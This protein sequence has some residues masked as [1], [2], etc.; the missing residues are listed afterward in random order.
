MTQHYESK[1]N[2]I[3]YRVIFLR[4]KYTIM[5]IWEDSR[6]RL[7]TRNIAPVEMKSETLDELKS[8]IIRAKRAIN[9]PIVLE[10]E[11]FIPD[12]DDRD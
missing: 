11:I 3:G 7:R 4:G 12:E 5:D 9:L 10:D 6:G 2:D 1:G 8:K